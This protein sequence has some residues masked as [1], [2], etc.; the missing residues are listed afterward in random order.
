MQSSSNRYI[1]KLDH[2]RALAVYM[3]F[4]YHFLHT[5]SV[6]PLSQSPRFWPA[7]LLD[8]GYTGVSLFMVLS[9]YLF[10]EIIGERK[11]SISYFIINRMLRLVLLYTM[12]F[13]LWWPWFWVRGVNIADNLIPGFFLSTWPKGGWSIAT[14][15]HFYLIL[16][17]LLT[18]RRRCGVGAWI[19]L[20]FLF[21]A[22]RAAIWLL[23]S[24]VQVLAYRTLIGR[25]DQFLLGMLFQQFKQTRCAERLLPVIALTLG[26]AFVVLWHE[27]DAAGGF[28]GLGGYPSPNPI[29][30]VLPTIEGIAYAA[31]IA[32]YDISPFRLPRRL[33][34]LLCKIGECSY[35]IYLWHFFAIAAVSIVLT[36]F[37]PTVS[38]GYIE[39]FLIGN[40][41]FT[42]VAGM[43]YV[44]YSLIERP[45]LRL[46]VRYLR[47]LAP[48][49]TRSAVVSVP[50]AGGIG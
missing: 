1:L 4:S 8:E 50:A 47:P 5:E 7:S 38:V 11:I 22:I 26:A 29:W 18:I 23:E 46:R 12:V 6:I 19:L 32:W 42:S 24:Q 14:E 21:V 13:I 27:F 10:A 31:F 20:I 17:F 39:W 25:I 28:Y 41:L 35:S 30:I 36:R 43:A 16:P 34:W 33:D 15:F 44:S 49:Q 40:V 48:V 9:G 37:A 3:V 2:I 45:F